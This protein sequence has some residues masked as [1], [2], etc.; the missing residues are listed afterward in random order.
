[1]AAL[2]HSLD[3][4]I[5]DLTDLDSYL[6]KRMFGCKAIYLHGLMVLVMADSEA[7]WRGLLFPVDF[8]DHESLL[9]EFDCLQQH[10]ILKK[11]LYLSSDSENFELE[12][13]KLIRAIKR[14]DRRLGI[15]PK[16]RKKSKTRR[17][18]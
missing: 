7:P 4:L 12:A 18:R 14:A 1:M 8:E 11:W 16:E 3:Y 6:S 2:T 17:K 5:E 13:Q 9:G 10:P 15:T